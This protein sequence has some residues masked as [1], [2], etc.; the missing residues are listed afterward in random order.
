MKIYKN[1]AFVKDMI[2]S[3][4]ESLKARKFEAFL[5]SEALS[6]N[7]F[8]NQKASS[9]SLLKIEFNIRTS[10]FAKLG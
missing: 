7:R 5:E 8:E 3:Q 4:V 9:E 10:S 1:T 6:R 2:T